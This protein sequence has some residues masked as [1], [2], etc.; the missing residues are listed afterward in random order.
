MK[1]HDPHPRLIQS[2]YILGRMRSLTAFVAGQPFKVAAYYHGKTQTSETRYAYPSN[3]TG[4]EP[5]Q[6]ITCRIRVI[7][8]IRKP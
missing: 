1:A 5:G 2:R 7:P 6:R 4:R 3:K 8:K